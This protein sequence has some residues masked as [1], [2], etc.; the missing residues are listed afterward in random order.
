MS[1]SKNTLSVVIPVY[2]ERQTIE[3]TLHKVEMAVLPNGWVKEIIIVDD[4][5]TDGTKEIL[6]KLS[7]KFQVLFR[8]ENGGKG[9]ALKDGFKVAKGD[10]ILIQDADS[11]YNPSDYSKLLQPIIDKRTEVVFGS[12]VLSKDSVPFSQIYFYGGLL[13]TK[14]FNLLF[15]SKLTDLATCY[16]VFPKEYIKDVIS[17][18]SDDFVFDV[19]EL[20]YMLFR[21][22]HLIIEV[23]VHYNSRKKAQ[24][25]KMNWRHGWRCF[26]R[27][28]AL[29]L[30]ERAVRTG[31]FFKRHFLR[32]KTYLADK[33]YLQLILIFSFFFLVFFGVYFWVSTL[34]SS[35]DHLFHFRFAQ[36]LFQHGFFQSFQ[37]FKSIYFSKIAQGNTYFVYYNFLFYLV[38]IPFTFIQPLYLGIKLYAVFAIAI[39]FV[40]L[41]ICLKKFEVKNPFVLTILFVAITAVPYLY[42]FFLSR[43]YALAPSLL[44]VLL[45]FLYKKNHIGVFVISFIYIYWHSATFFMP[46]GVSIAYYIS[47]RFYRPKGDY[48]NMIYSFAGTGVAVALTYAVSSGFLLYMRDIIFGTYWDTILGKKVNIAEGGE[49]YPQDFFNFIQGN[50][51]IFATFVTALSID[52]FSYVGYKLRRVKD[53][54]G[55]V[56][57][58]RRH[59]HLCVLLLTI[60]FFLGTVVMSAR[61]EDYFTFFAALYIALSFDY[62]RRIMSVEGDSL[63]RRSIGF[64]L[65]VVLIYLFVSNMLFL[66]RQLAYGAQPNEFYE[67]G[68]W[69]NNNTK[70]GDIIFNNNWSWFTGLYY[71]S[72][73]DNY[74]VGLEPRF[75]YTLSPSI[76]WQWVHIANDG[77][78]C[79]TEK[80]TDFDTA[81]NTALTIST[82]TASKW[83]KTESSEIAYTLLNT[84]HTSYVVTSSDYTV[85][86]AIMNQSDRFQKEFTDDQ[87]GYMIYK[88]KE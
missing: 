17:L 66:Q 22:K 58:E 61:F 71:Y 48:K 51:L 83:I 11:E 49:L 78:V 24:G 14:I 60:S 16:K 37:N 50:A 64:G 53:Y 82:T 34:S 15:R 62:V 69:L 56:S 25:K 80:C 33:T 43:P 42:R 68:L 31:G 29:F 10:Y 21:E 67:T 4:A 87:Y 35:D 7:G 13:V 85:F 75:T 18:P 41:Y 88:V 79:S 57:P 3:E 70:P 63:I 23:P 77:Y 20:S 52:I 46:F 27:I 26:K 76:Y 30:F 28:I 54:W 5:S 39:A 65:I 45:L 8:D 55:G 84:F 72:P 1:E 32:L 81:K 6:R 47:E 59:L 73:Q 36:Q 19:V 86:N 44:L 38:I 74:I 12:R 2:N 9:A 40:L